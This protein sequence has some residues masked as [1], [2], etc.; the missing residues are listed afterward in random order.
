MYR[1]NATLVGHMPKQSYCF[2]SYSWTTQCTLS[3]YCINLRSRFL[4]FSG[5]HTVTLSGLETVTLVTAIALYPDSHGINT[6]FLVPFPVSI[7]SKFH[8]AKSVFMI[9]TFMK[10]NP[11]VYSFY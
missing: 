2:L 3:T 11:K 6:C 8:E 9:R 1:A 10:P 4:V 7:N 5:T